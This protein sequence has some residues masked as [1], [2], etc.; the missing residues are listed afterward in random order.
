MN[1][2]TKFSPNDMMGQVK[3]ITT[4]FHVG[5]INSMLMFFLKRILLLKNILN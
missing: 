1:R 3:K 4:S 2:L 5:S